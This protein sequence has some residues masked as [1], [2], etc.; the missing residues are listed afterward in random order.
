[1]ASS[2]LSLRSCLLRSAPFIIR[3]SS[4]IPSHLAS[5]QAAGLPQTNAISLK[6]NSKPSFFHSVPKV[7]GG[8]PPCCIAVFRLQA[9]GNSTESTTARNVAVQV[10]HELL[11]AGHH[12]L[13]VRTPEEFAAGHVEGA[14]N[15]PYMFKAGS[16]MT[17]NLK[18]VEEVSTHFDKDDEIVVGCQSGKR[19]SM[20]V[21]ELFASEF[22]GVSNV[23]GG[24]GAWV[25]SGLPVVQ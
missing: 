12:Y 24:Y 10:A 11:N 7:A 19:S 9:Q 13:D 17:K 23:V 4:S 22:S 14:V 5:F 25:E 18:F 15:I 3:I 21:A 20:A 8:W 1:M 2:A 16:G 6:P